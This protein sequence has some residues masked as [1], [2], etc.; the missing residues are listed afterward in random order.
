MLLAAA[1]VSL[2]AAAPAPKVPEPL[3]AASAAASALP[4]AT[5]W[6]LPPVRAGVKVEAAEGDGRK[7]LL[8]CEK[9][10]LKIHSLRGTIRERSIILGVDTQPSETETDFWMRPAE[11]KVRFEKS[12]PLPHTVVFNGKHLWVWSPKENAALEAEAADLDAAS[13]T[14][15]DVVPGFGIDVIAPVGLDQYRTEV[16]RV[17]G[18]RTVVIL[19]PMDSAPSRATIQIVVDP[20]KHVVERLVIVVGDLGIADSEMMDFVEAKP[21]IFFPS[22]VH[23]RL[24]LPDGTSVEKLRMYE[25][26]KYDAPIE[27]AKFTFDVPADAKR[28]PLAQGAASASVGSSAASGH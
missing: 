13:R 20:A 1:L 11:E 9:H 5:P 23:S 16:K 4:Q 8:D 12:V 10:F 25:R 26:M 21:G 6:I 27:D 3:P 18:T 28:I 24:L 22:R 17:E 15:F 2:F 14:A 19:T 7:L